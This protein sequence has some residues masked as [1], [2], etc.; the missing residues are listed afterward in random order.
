MWGHERM[1]PVVLFWIVLLIPLLVGCGQDRSK[2]TPVQGQVYYKGRPLSGG[3]IVFTPDPERGGRGPMAF[4]EIHS[5]GH[6]SLITEQQPGAVP[7]WHRITVLG[8]VP[9]AEEGEKA[10][11]LPAHYSDPEH[12]G[13]VCKVKPGVLNIQDLRLD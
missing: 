4:G 6:Y 7:G 10:V 13:L 5:D 1:R 8:A 9:P 11:P 3:T 2:P 12:S